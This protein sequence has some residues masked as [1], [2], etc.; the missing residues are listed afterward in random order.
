MTTT[1]ASD[2]PMGEDAIDALAGEYVLG[3][4]SAS[5]RRAVEQRLGSEPALRQAI[6]SWEAKLH[7]LVE[8]VE[9]M[10]PSPQLWARIEASI[11]P[12]QAASHRAGA[13][14]PARWTGSSA[15][16]PHR[17]RRG[18]RGTARWSGWG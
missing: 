1:G 3:T 18:P 15:R 16:R 10:A 5:A 11:S 17:G 7:P 6:A 13:A 8:T 12:A 9:P 14:R 4:L 2:D